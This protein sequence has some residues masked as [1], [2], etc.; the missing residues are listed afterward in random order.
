MKS[1]P[2]IGPEFYRHLLLAGALGAGFCLAQSPSTTPQQGSPALLPSIMAPSITAPG[3]TVLRT[4]RAVI[5]RSVKV[6]SAAEGPALEIVTS[7]SQ[8]LAPTIESLESPPRLVIDLPNTRFRLPDKRLA[9]DSAQ[10]TRVRINQFRDAP[11]VTRIVLD[12]IHPVGYST[13][14]TGERLLV[15]LH[16]LAEARERS[17]EPPSVPALTPGVQPVAVPVSSGSSGVV[18]EAGSRLGGDSSVTAALET[19]ILHLTRGGEVRVCPGTTLSVTTSQNGHDLMLGMSTGAL[20]AHYTLNSS[21]DSVLTPDFR[22]LLAGP[23]EFHFAIS[24]DTRGNTCVRSLPGN[25]ASVIVSELMGD[26]TYQVK[27]SERAVFHSGRLSQIDAI[28]PDECGCPPP[29]IP[30]MRASVEPMPTV[31]EKDLPP[32]VHLAQPGDGA[33]AQPIGE[34]T[35]WQS[36]RDPSSQVTLTIVPPDV[37]PLPAPQPGKAR[38]QIDAPFVFRAAD[39][40]PSAPNLESAALPM[41]HSAGQAPLLT[42][43]EPP[44]EAKPPGV[45]GKM[46]RFFSG[47]FK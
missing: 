16:P 20:E 13:D 33:K 24:A 42:T 37:A 34:A 46:K 2:R 11:P 4:P 10:I 5:L 22:M 9:G 28:V 38:V 6:I 18:V 25:T 12:L 29:E 45:L 21:A 47:L 41:S 23:G 15:H 19:T 32:T 39:S 44:A 27:S 17:L 7:S 40:A 43:A 31:S 30:A 26:G 35:S 14:G 8:A 36:A 1:L 3:I